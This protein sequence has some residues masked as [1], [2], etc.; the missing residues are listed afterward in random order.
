[1]VSS[2]T[3]PDIV[4]NSVGRF[5]TVYIGVSAS[6]SSMNGTT[7]FNTGANYYA[8]YSSSVVVYD[9]IAR[10][11]GNVTCYINEYFTSESDLGGVLADSKSSTKDH[12]APKRNGNYSG[13]TWCGVHVDFNVND[14]KTPYAYVRDALES[15]TTFPEYLIWAC[16]DS[17]RNG[18]LLLA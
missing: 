9:C 3:V 18:Y 11:S 12:I 7:S 4:K 1:M 8:I 10:I 15:L 2:T 13:Q 16:K 6:V 14:N 17:S 5:N